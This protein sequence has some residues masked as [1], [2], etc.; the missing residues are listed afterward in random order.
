[1]T[2][3]SIVASSVDGFLRVF[4]IRM[5]KM[6]RFGQFES[7]N[8]IDIGLD[9]NFVAVSTLDSNIHLIDITDG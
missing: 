9:P 1:M 2:N 4:D 7:I 6:L 5:M 8:S 3:H